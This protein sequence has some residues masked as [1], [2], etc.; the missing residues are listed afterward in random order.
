MAKSVDLVGD[1]VMKK[2]LLALRG[3]FEEIDRDT[4]G[5]FKDAVAFHCLGYQSWVCF[6]HS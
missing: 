2:E 4:D 6:A 3:F 1:A 5:Y